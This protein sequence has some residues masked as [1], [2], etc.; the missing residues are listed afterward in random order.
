MKWPGKWS[1]L[2]LA[3]WLILMGLVQLGVSFPY[4]ALVM[5]VL[6]LVAGIL[7]FLDR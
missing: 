1:V 2:L 4:S 5:G 6:A 7:V 3:V